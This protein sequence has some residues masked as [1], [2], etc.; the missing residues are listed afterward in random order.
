MECHLE[1]MAGELGLKRALLLSRRFFTP[2]AEALAGAE[3]LRA[4][5]FVRLRKSM[6]ALQMAH[7]LLLRKKTNLKERLN[8]NSAAQ[9]RLKTTARELSLSALESKRLQEQLRH[10]S[11]RIIYAQ[12]EDRKRISRELHDEVSAALTGVNLELNLLE[13]HVPR[14]NLNLLEKVIRTQQLV[15]NVGRNIHRF[16]RELRP[17]MLDDLGLIPTLHAFTKN[18]SRQSGLRISLTIFAGVEAMAN[19]KKTALYRVI[20]EA[21]TNAMKHAGAT[22]VDITLT[23]DK[24]LV[25]LSIHDNGKSFKPARLLRSREPKRLGLLG[26]RERIEMLGGEFSIES[27]RG[28]GTTIRGSIPNVENT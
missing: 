19:E 21:L 3:E 17:A 20:Q 7:A 13:N 4:R 9:A 12:E 6:E 18:I 14:A 2:I 26:M 5:Q 10:L 25:I 16:A 11:H 8:L 15:L 1:G 23:H 28:I 24:N 22:E 27:Q